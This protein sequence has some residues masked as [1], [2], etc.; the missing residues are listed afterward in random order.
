[1][2]HEVGNGATGPM[3][4][5]LQIAKLTI[6]LIKSGVNSMILVGNFAE[7][8][9]TQQQPPWEEEINEPEFESGRQTGIL[10]STPIACAASIDGSLSQSACFQS[11]CSCP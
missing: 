7:G 8:D 6:A 3:T 2:E 1:M 10:R 5:L 11:C 9:G 4:I